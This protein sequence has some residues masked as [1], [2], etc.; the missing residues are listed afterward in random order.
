MGYVSLKAIK[1]S[2]REYLPGDTIEAEHILP[3]R[4]R[5]L[6]AEGCIAEVADTV[7]MHTAELQEVQT[8]EEVKFFI[9]VVCTDDGNAAQAMSVPLTEGE[10]QHVFA[11]MQMN[12]EKATEEIEGVESE[13]ALI[14]LHAADSRKMVKQAAQKQAGKLMEEA[15]TKAEG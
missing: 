1:L 14:V 2:G 3:K 6:I 13:N 7:E 5:A 12:V 10:L 15:A 4:K 8:G 11:I 9:P